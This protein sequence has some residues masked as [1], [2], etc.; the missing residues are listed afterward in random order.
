MRAKL[1]GVNRGKG[2]IPR[3]ALE[4]AV[5]LALEEDIGRGDLTTWVCIPEQQTA[6]AHVVT[7]Q[8]LILSGLPAVRRVF[9]RVHASVQLV[10]LHDDGSRLPARSVIA[11]LVGPA[12]ALLA[13]ERVALN[14]LQRL[15]GVATATHSYVKQLPAGCRTRIAD[16]RKTTPGLRALERYAVRC[17]G[18]YNH[19]GDL[20]S[21]VLI[22]DNHVA[23]C[24]SLDLAIRRARA[25]APHTTRIG[26]EVDRLAQLDEAIAAGADWIL[27]DNFSPDEVAAAVT[28]ISGRAIVE[29]SGGIQAS[30]VP[31]LASSGVDVISVGALTHSAAALDIGLDWMH[32]P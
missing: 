7:R 25:A 11:E 10:A 1:G 17:G 21:G 27:L 13:G 28:S 20:A 15:S 8:D 18:G 32:Q 6:R 31:A 23:A 16:T 24:G 2:G 26:C 5:E 9:E 14:F 3:A 4:K 12:R 29:A 22:K 19:R 30:D